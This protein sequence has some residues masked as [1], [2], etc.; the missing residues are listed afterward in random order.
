MIERIY[1]NCLGAQED[2]SIHFHVVVITDDHRIEGEVQDFKGEVLRVDDS[3]STGTD[4]VALAFTRH[5][6]G[7]NWDLVVNMQGDEPLLSGRELRKL[8]Q[9]HLA[10]HF[11]IYTLVNENP[12]DDHFHDPGNVKAVFSQQNGQCLYFSRNPIPFGAEKW[13]LHIGVYSYRPH[14][15]LQFAGT[16]PS[17]YEKLERLEQLRA[18]EGGMAI[19]AL[20]TTEIL[21]GV[22]DPQDIVRVEA[23]L[24]G[25]E[26]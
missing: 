9:A 21:L 25:K 18:L 22:D 26:K 2:N 13:Y 10:S 23:L 15:L 16:P 11:P 14:A 5:F 19:G 6:K 1:H 3:V 4:R 17:F 20:K 12:I 8:V 7:Q 24:D